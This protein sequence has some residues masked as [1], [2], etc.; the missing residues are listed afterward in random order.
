[1]V[2]VAALRVND[3]DIFSDNK[4]SA[5]SSLARFR[6]VDSAE[7][8]AFGPIEHVRA[9]HPKNGRGS[10]L[11]NGYAVFAQ[12]K[13][14]NGKHW[15]QWSIDIDEAPQVRAWSISTDFELRMTSTFR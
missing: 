11:R 4:Q 3:S 6:F 9:I 7:S 15:Q 14:V 10:G 12:Q 5:S 13:L 2:M 1:M 8:K